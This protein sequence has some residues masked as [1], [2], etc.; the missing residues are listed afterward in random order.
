MAEATT[1]LVRRSTRERLK[2]LG[3]KGETYDALLSRL[4]DMAEAR[5]AEWTLPARRHLRAPSPHLKAKVKL[6]E[7]AVLD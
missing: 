7:W 1:I 3:A 4:A 5:G 2:L 6:E